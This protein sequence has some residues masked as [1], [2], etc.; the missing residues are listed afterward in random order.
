MPYD[1]VGSGSPYFGSGFVNFDRYLNEPNI[2]WGYNVL[3]EN[4]EQPKSEEYWL[5]TPEFDE[6]ITTR[7]GVE[8]EPELTAYK[9]AW[10]EAHK[11][12]PPPPGKP[13]VEA[14]P[15]DPG[16]SREDI[17]EAAREEKRKAKWGGRYKTQ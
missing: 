6:W 3:K 16:L 15:K 10:D 8:K 9:S 13:P 14:P 12:P 1:P 5:Q 17:L 2:G 4:I 11:P 7:A